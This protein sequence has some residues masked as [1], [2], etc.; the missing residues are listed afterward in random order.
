M[1]RSASA[2]ERAQYKKVLR[3]QKV[4]WN[5]L[6]H[7][8]KKWCQC[9]NTSIY[10]KPKRNVCHSI[11]FDKEKV[12]VPLDWKQANHAEMLNCKWNIITYKLTQKAHLK[13]WSFF[14]FCHWSGWQRFAAQ[15]R[16]LNSSIILTSAWF[17]STSQIQNTQSE[18]VRKNTLFC[19]FFCFKLE[20]T[21]SLTFHYLLYSSWK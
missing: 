21:R 16:K 20:Y 7:L 1:Q 6:L 9:P 14:I 3:K 19:C 8:I 12:F 5:I 10:K 11:A 4:S 18:G 2:V 13:P 15:D 17:N